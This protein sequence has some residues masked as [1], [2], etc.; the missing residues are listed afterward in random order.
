MERG[1]S[2]VPW[3]A[4]Q[5]RP[6]YE[7]LV[8][9]S[10]AN[11]GYESFLPLFLSRHRWSDR[12]VEVRMP[13]FPGY[14]FCRLDFGGRLMPVIT[15]PGFVR[16]VGFGSWPCPVEDDEIERVEQI[17]RS[18]LDS[19]PWPV[20]QAG[21]RVRLEDGP[22]AGLEGTLVST[23]SGHRLVVTVS[24]LQRAV[25]VEVDEECVRAIEADGAADLAHPNCRSPYVRRGEAVNRLG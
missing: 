17:V 9:Q 7:A 10:L 16:V 23:R 4:L 12:V 22:L 11:K 13:V 18:G 2:N 3:Y 19:R 14:L 5:V 20:P 21:Q 15:T 8:A 1:V 25:A 6:R 24:L